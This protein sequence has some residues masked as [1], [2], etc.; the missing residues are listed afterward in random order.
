MFDPEE[1]RRCVASVQ[2]R[3]KGLGDIS[4]FVINSNELKHGYWIK[5][6]SFLVSA[7]K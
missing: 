5:I 2:I 1:K 3:E 6:F 4:H 7:P